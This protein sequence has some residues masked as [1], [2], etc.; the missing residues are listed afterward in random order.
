METFTRLP[1]FLC[2]ACAGIVPATVSGLRAQTT[3]SFVIHSKPAV[4]RTDAFW[5]IHFDLHANEGDTILGRDATP[6]NIGAFLDR[7][8]PDFVQYDCKGHPGYTGYPT[9]VGYPSPGIVKD[10]LAIWRQETA[11]RHIGLFIHYSGVWDTAALKHHPEW[12]RIDENGNPDPNSTS[13]F[14]DY[15]RDL[16]IPQLKEVTSKYNLDGVWVDGDCW[17]ARLDYGTTAA[18]AWKDASGTETMPRKAGEPNWQQWKTFNRNAYEQYLVNWISE[19]HKFNPTLELCSNWAYTPHMPMPIKADVDFISGDFSAKESVDRARFEARY[20]ES[21]GKP[22]DLMAWGFNGFHNSSAPHQKKMPEQLMQE[23]AVVMALGG[24]VQ[25][26]YQ[27]T[28][29]GYVSST[30]TDIAGQVGDFCRQR[31]SFSHKSKTIP[32]VAVLLSSKSY[33]NRMDNVFAPGGQ[34]NTLEGALHLLLD[35]GYSVDMMSEHQLAPRL[36]EFPVIVVSQAPLLAPAFHKKLIDYV[37][38]GG[39]LVLLDSESAAP[40]IAQLGVSYAGKSVDTDAYLAGGNITAPAPGSWQKIVTL[41][42]EPLAYRTNADGETTDTTTPGNTFGY[43]KSVR[44]IAATR[45][46]LGKGQIIAVY[47]PVPQA[48]FSAHHPAVR[49][50]VGQLMKVAL[51]RPKAKLNGAPHVDMALRQL[52]DGRPAVHLVNL[53]ETQRTERFAALDHLPSDAGGVLIWEMPAKPRQIRQE[54]EGNHLEFKTFMN[55]DG[56]CRCEIPIERVPIHSVIL[57]EF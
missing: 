53:A 1:V 51:P 27:P 37:E 7:V 56:T 32:Q 52:N 4:S 28:R 55:P 34:Y 43:V 35:N 8:K 38:N 9:K 25:V 40:F 48:Y 29:G 39:T 46:S 36:K 16:M 18:L 49:E 45:Q 57:P 10:A 2:V 11:R 42:A 3:A 41:N 13:V 6:E 26:Y 24:G 15:A 21:T 47:G 12:A 31:Q 54:P 5:G 19:L 17:A 20:L 50:W 22:W 33:F 44:E 30:I 23:A 14:G